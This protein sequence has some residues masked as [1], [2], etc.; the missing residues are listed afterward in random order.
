MTKLMPGKLYIIG[1]E[2]GFYKEFQPRNA[3]FVYFPDNSI[4]MLLYYSFTNQYDIHTNQY[5]IKTMWLYHGKIYIKWFGV[6]SLTEEK[7]LNLKELT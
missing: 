4:F 1:P 3:D 5:D 2:I 7:M 6:G